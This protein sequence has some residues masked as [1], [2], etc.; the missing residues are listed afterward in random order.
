MTKYS[1]SDIVIL[2]FISTKSYQIKLWKISK[3]HWYCYE[4]K[5]LSLNVIVQVSVY[6]KYYDMSWSSLVVGDEGCICPIRK[7]L[8]LC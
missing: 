3:I 2:Y 6:M 5:R 7:L 8:C 4:I 1:K